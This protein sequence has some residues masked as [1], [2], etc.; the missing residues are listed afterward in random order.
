MLAFI[1]KISLHCI[2]LTLLSFP[3]FSQDKES[4]VIE[5]MYRPKLAE[6]S[7]QTL[8]NQNSI[9]S[10]EIFGDGTYEVE[11][12]YLFKGKM[13][14]PLFMKPGHLAALQLT[15]EDIRFS[16]DNDININSDLFSYLDQTKKFRGVSARFLYERKLN[17]LASFNLISGLEMHSDRWQLNSNT[18]KYYIAGLYTQVISNRTQIGYGAITGIDQQVFSLWPLFKMEHKINKKWTIDILLPKSAAL[19]FQINPKTYLIA[20]TEVNTW[21]YNL[22]GQMLNSDIPDFTLRRADLIST[23]ILE[24]EIHDWLWFSVEGGMSNNLSYY[25]AEPGLRNRNA[26]VGINVKETGYFKFNVFVVPP[27]KMCKK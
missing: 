14:I 1:R 17:D 15:Y 21:R 16:V 7:Y 13:G 18:I 24:R 27:W 11:S 26:T 6:F 19:R 3:L 20:Q 9:A 4:N 12:N 25:L 23:I 10:S 22:D 2:A 8:F 5:G